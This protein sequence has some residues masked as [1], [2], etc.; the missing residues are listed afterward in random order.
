MHI[1]W[2]HTKYICHVI[3]CLPEWKTFSNYQSYI[4]MSS[5]LFLAQYV[6]IFK[7]IALFYLILTRC[8]LRAAAVISLQF[9]KIKKFICIFYDHHSVYNIDSVWDINF[10]FRLR[11]FWVYYSRALE[12][13]P[14]WFQQ[15]D[16]D[17]WRSLF[18]YVVAN[19]NK[20]FGS[21]FPYCHWLKTPGE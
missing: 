11:W 18:R 20:I 8:K 15:L 17:C 16:I 9:M 1:F 14:T 3:F 6:Y 12:T 7:E 4:T 19:A 21:L 2:L 5:F 13:K 10:N